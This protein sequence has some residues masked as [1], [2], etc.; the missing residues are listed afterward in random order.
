MG[1]F[2]SKSKT[3]TQ[4]LYDTDTNTVQTDQSGNSGVNISGGGSLSSDSHDVSTVD[5]RSFNDSRDMSVRDSGNVYLDAGAVR[6]GLDLAQTALSFANEAGANAAGLV[7]S[8]ANRALQFGSD[9]LTAVQRVNADSL[10]LLGGLVTQTIDA[11]KTLAREGAQ[12]NAS[13]LADALGGF[14]KLAVQNS[15]TSD[16]K[17]TRVIGFALAA[18]AAVV[19]LP[20]LF[21]GGGRAVI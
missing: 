1:F 6:G 18:V 4:T 5:S 12:A 15:E 20:A 3:V 13:T 8:G 16:D 17:I 9:A 21:K 7:Q 11:S 2:D 10:S 14:Q 19:V